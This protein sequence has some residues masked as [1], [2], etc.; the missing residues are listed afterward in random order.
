MPIRFQ[1]GASMYDVTPV[2]NMFIE[3]YM[4]QVPGDFVKVYLYGLMLCYRGEEG[5][6]GLAD[7]ASALDLTCEQVRAAFAC[8]A[9]K[10]VLRVVTTDPL[11]VEYF[12]L[13]NTFITGSRAQPMKGD[14]EYEELCQELQQMFRSQ[15]ML[16]HSDLLLVKDWLDTLHMEGP[17]VVLLV[18]LCLQEKGSKV[19]FAYLDKV[20]RSR[21]EAGDNTFEAVDGYIKR[22]EAVNS[23]AGQLLRRWNIQRAPSDDEM[24]L[25][26]KW[27]Q[28]W[29]FEESAIQAAAG[30]MAGSAYPNF[31]YLDRILD[32][33]RREDD[34]RSGSG[35]AR[36]LKARS[37]QDDACLALIRALGL[38]SATPSSPAVRELYRRRIAQNF[39]PEALC[40]AASTLERKGR[41][42]L[43]HLDAL[44]D[45]YLEQGLVTLGA[46]EAQNARLEQEIEGVQVWLQLWG[47]SRA[48]TENELKAYR[49][50]TQEWKLPAEV[51]ECAARDSVSASYPLNY[52]SRILR[53]CKE[54]GIA[55]AQQY[56]AQKTAAQPGGLKDAAERDYANRHQYTEQDY[57]AMY[58]DI[59]DTK[60]DK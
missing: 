8:W 33:L 50:F 12:N 58:T 60:D 39:T 38:R 3:L 42:T 24:A 52:M 32:T 45:S 46:I 29:G 6:A 9:E 48:P 49:V 43:E 41:S 17:A 10:G 23:G 31:K 5:A 30:E 44:L 36:A 56:A 57:Q 47:M 15:R 59:F 14:S 51:L 2:E 16:S 34:E 54:K 53:T 21:A 1:P 13:K 18:S 11:E 27:R 25:Y 20:M 37:A 55:T 40:A 28:D 22:R 35:V 4:G 7:V 26:R 19:S